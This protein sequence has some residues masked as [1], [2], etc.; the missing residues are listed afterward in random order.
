MGAKRLVIH[1]EVGR[2]SWSEAYYYR[3]ATAD[4]SS[5]VDPAMGL[6]QYRAYLL[7]I[8]ATVTKAFLS[9]DDVFRDQLPLR[10]PDK[11]S[12]GSYNSEWPST[13]S[14]HADFPFMA[15]PVRCASGSNNNKLIYMSGMP[16]AVTWAADARPTIYPSG[17]TAAFNAFVARLVTSW[18]WKGVKSVATGAVKSN[19]ASVSVE[20]TTNRFIL[21]YSAS[22]G[23]IEGQTILV[24]SAKTKGGGL[25]GRAGIVTIANSGLTVTL[26]KKAPDPFS[27][28]GG[29]FT[30]LLDYTLYPITG[31][32]FQDIT[33]RKRGGRY[34]LPRGRV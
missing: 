31:A 12:N 26:D 15:I 16:D 9:E 8:G 13:A 10:L 20:T 5:I 7:G 30:F 17:F 18:A 11:V 27:Y 14:Y 32:L 2:Y 23:Y 33:H 1:F 24:R 28:F 29:G 22:P 19:I 25:N 6:V 21:K 3:D 34:D 4:L